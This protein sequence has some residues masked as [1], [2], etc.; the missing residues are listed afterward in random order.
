VKEP[1]QCDE[2]RKLLREI[3]AK[4]GHVSIRERFSLHAD[5]RTK[6]RKVSD[7][8]CLAAVRAGAVVGREFEKGTWRYRVE[9]AGVCL[10]VAFR[11]ESEFRIVTAWRT[12]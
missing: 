1:L 5:D 8:E 9:A 4:K 6:V 7:L 11:S 10:I 2:P 12:D 3:L